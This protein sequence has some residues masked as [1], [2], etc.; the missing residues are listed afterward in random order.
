MNNIA[1]V[2]RMIRINYFSHPLEP[3]YYSELAQH[4]IHYEFIN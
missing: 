2:V 3:P 4:K 1:A